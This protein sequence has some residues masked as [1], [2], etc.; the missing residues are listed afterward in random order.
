MNRIT[1]YSA[2]SDTGKFTLAVD[3]MD[4]HVILAN[5]VRQGWQGTQWDVDF[6]R[7]C[8]DR[9]LEARRY[10]ESLTCEGK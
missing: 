8:V 5:I 7:H 3:L 2:V 4:T 6:H 1:K 10:A 9:A